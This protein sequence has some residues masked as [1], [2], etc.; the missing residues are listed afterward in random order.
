MQRVRVEGLAAELQ[1]PAG[2]GPFPAVIVLHEAVGLNADIRRIGRRFVDEGYAVLAPDL[3]SGGP[4]P[5]CIARTVTDAFRN[6]GRR[7]AA[8][9]G[10]LRDWLAGRPDVDGDRIGVVGFCM[11][12]GSALA[13]G[14]AH[15]FAVSGVN[16]GQVPEDRSAVEGTCPVVASFGAED[17]RLLPHAE[18]L[19]RWL[20][21]L[22]VDHDVRV[23]P[24]AG[25]GFVNR[26]VPAFVADRVPAAGYVEEAAEDAWRRML[27]FFAERLHPAPGPAA[28][29][30][31][32]HAP[33]GGA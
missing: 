26:S 9:I 28:P 7:T 29:T 20:T 18:R 16:Y 32:A 6:G 5:L 23:Y 25:H 22:G 10:G 21:E 14:V 33:E 31:S 1:L 8:R 19:E 4:R 24:G 13:A 11:S 3:F 2:T 30:P 17:R 15:R 12:G 27:A